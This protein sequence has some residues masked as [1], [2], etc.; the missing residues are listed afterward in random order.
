MDRIGDRPIISVNGASPFTP[1][2]FDVDGDRRCTC[3]RTLTLP[4]VDLHIILNAC[5]PRPRFLL[6]HA[7]FGKIWPIN[8]LTP[9][10]ENVECAP[11]CCFW[12]SWTP[13]RVTICSYV[14]QLECYFNTQVC[15]LYKVSEKLC[16][17][18]ISYCVSRK[19]IR[20]CVLVRVAWTF[21]SEFKSTKII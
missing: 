3:K 15:K 18:D 20:T 6:F 5:L 16:A 14:H 9:P 17:Q 2:K 1:C 10:L 12:S 7:V 11:D 21:F 8:R 4:V 19:Y 13:V